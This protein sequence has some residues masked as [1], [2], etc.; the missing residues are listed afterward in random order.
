MTEEIAAEEDFFGD[1]SLGEEAGSEREPVRRQLD[2]GAGHPGDRRH[3]KQQNARRTR[4]RHRS[5]RGPAEAK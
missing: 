4:G 5:R 2:G 1:T 3:A